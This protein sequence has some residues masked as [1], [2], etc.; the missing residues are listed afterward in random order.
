MTVSAKENDGGVHAAMQSLVRYL[1]D[2]KSTEKGAQKLGSSSKDLFGS[3]ADAKYIR[4]L[5]TAED[6]NFVPLQQVGI[7]EVTSF[8]VLEPEF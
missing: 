2:K 8:F 5:G 7:T 1:L 3:P 4:T 6:H